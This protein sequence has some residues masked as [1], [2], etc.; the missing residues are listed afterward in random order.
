M[1][2]VRCTNA[3]LIT[4][5]SRLLVVL[6][7][8]A[9]L[10]QPAA[11]QAEQVHVR[12]AEGLVHGFLALRSLDGKKLADGELIQIAE[13]DRVN[14][15]LT[16]R[17]NDGS[18]YDDSTIYSQRG[19]F[20]L[21][22]DHLIQKGPSFKQPMD[23]SLDASTGKVTVRYTDDK[24]K[25][26][27]LNKQV[28]MPPD[29][30]N[31]LL[32]TI[33]KHVQPSAPQTTVSMLATT[34]K[35]RLVKLMIVPQGEVPFTSGATKQKAERYLVKFKLGGLAGLIAPLVGKQPPD[36]NVWVLGGD[37]PAFVKSEGPLYP[38]GPI[39][40]VELAVPAGFP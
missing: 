12:H 17:F 9:A 2:R 24:G 29:L 19:D 11:L 3:D 22:S 10:L 25:E 31:G 4:Y 28:D 20:R 33:V 40:R 1:S 34:P 13:G 18:L 15:R 32:F 16:F 27:V 26:K 35:P 21:L 39:W 38:D 36:M 23:T 8:C 37:A 6:L 30:A 7:S 5:W 14:S